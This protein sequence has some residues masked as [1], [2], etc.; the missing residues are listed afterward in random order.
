MDTR[1]GGEETAKKSGYH[2]GHLR[3]ALLD[4]AHRLIAESGPESFTLAEACRQAGVSTAAPYRHFAD[5][6]ALVEAVAA[7]GFDSLS[8]RTR[9]A[10]DAHPDG[11]VA[12][13]VAMGQAYVAFVTRDPAL[14]QLMWGAGAPE[15]QE[16]PMATSGHQCFGVL[17]Q[18]VDAFRR[19]QGLE[20]T[21]TL[22]IA[23]PLWTIVHGTA[24]LVLGER[25]EK[26]APGTDVD[27]LVEHTTRAYLTGLVRGNR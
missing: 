18:A 20:A 4:A 19:E 10:R 1:G 11:S 14:F 17:L 24:S 23:V 3:E 16:S 25:F 8:V 9:E 13:I 27:R 7:R 26:V 6:Q 12:S 21:D 5:R 2:H 22:A 15:R